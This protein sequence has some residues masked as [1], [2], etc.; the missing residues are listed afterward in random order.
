MKKLMIL[1]SAISIAAFVA[2]SGGSSKSGDDKD[3]TKT[4]DSTKTSGQP[5]AKYTLKSGIIYQDMET[6]G[7][8]YKVNMYFD[9]YGAKECVETKGTMD[10]GIAGKV[11]TSS[12]MITKDGYVY[13]IDLSTKTGTKSKVLANQKGKSDNIDFNNLTEAAMKEM[14]ITKEGTET[15]L[16]KTCDKFK[17]D[18]ADMNLKS[19]YCV[20]DG[21]AL[22]YEMNMAGITAKTTATKIEENVSVPAEKF[23]VPKDIKLTE[24]K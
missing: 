23:E 10:M 22:K 15:V 14:H 16:G 1:F 9:D 24:M 8:V 2:C 21:I 18:Y 19:S 4:A 5:G 12:I 11:E 7:M 6:M 3:T 20:W 13:Q 17:M